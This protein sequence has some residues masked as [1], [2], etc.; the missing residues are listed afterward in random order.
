MKHATS[1]IDCVGDPPF[2]IKA[3]D[4]TELSYFSKGPCDSIRAH[5]TG[6]ATCGMTTLDIVFE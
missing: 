2:G 4:G 6:P 5:Y 1:F 3:P